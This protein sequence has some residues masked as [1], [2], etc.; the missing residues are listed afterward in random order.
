MLPEKYIRLKDNVQGV[1]ID[2][3]GLAIWHPIKTGL[4]G[5]NLIEIV[6]GI[7][8][9]DNVINPV[10]SKKKLTGGMRVYVK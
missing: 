8:K 1:F 4:H 3:G 9:G 6:K 2:N 10:D 7:Q 5:G